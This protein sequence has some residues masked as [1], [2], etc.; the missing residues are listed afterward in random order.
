MTA[1]LRA[2]FTYANV[3]A[4]VAVFIALGGG[5]YAA[6]K[7]PANSVGSKQLKKS[8]VTSAKIAKNA[9]VSSKVKDGSLLATDFAAG[10]LPA[11]AQGPKGDTGAAGAAGA[12]GD[13]GAA[14]SALAFARVAGDGTLDA[15]NSKAVTVAS[16]P[17]IGVY[18]L[19]APADS[20]NIV[21]SVD[22]GSGTALPGDTVYPSL[23]AA[24]VASFC[25]PPA[26]AVVF[27]E[28]PSNSAKNAGFY[29]SIN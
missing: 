12:K 2:R 17:G 9:V 15:A 22:P 19:V 7:L 16:H 27:V 5:A 21:A 6:V 3:M 14:G 11:G 1:R 23:A 4:T 24:I 18:C 10:Q 29:V 25:A 28:D 20:K 13:T 26:T 8:A